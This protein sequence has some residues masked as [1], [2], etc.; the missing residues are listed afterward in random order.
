M[1]V[2]APG[3]RP[4]G[5]PPQTAG[6][7]RRVSRYDRAGPG[8]RPPRDP[9]ADPGGCHAARAVM[10]HFYLT[11]AAGVS[12]PGVPSQPDPALDQREGQRAGQAEDEWR[13][14]KAG[15]ER[16]LL[17][18]GGDWQVPEPVQR[19]DDHKRATDH[20]GLRY[21]TAARVAAVLSRVVGDSSVIPHD[22]QLVHGNG[23]VERN[24]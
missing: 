17:E 10:D 9:P 13:G 15:G 7:P 12:L 3:G 11:A 2:L 24:Q 16:P 19:P 21:R 22:P 14:G 18:R 4:P 8:G 1:T 6:V 23:G 5:I 20:L